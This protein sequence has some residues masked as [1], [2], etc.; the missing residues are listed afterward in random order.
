M[1]RLYDKRRWHRVRARKLA[2][3]QICEG[4]DEQPSRHVDHIQPLDKCGAEYDPA[5][6]MALCIPCHTEKTGC[7]KTGRQ[8]IM[9]KHRGCNVDGSARV[10]EK[11]TL[12]GGS[13]TATSR[14]NTAGPRKVELVR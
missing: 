9:P 10:S 11:P 13:I 5:N 2:R 1:G 8:W 12:G 14:A 7:D 3:D 6:H 4:C